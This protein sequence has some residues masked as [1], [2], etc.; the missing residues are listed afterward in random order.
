MPLSTDQPAA[1]DSD[2]LRERIDAALSRYTEF[3]ADC[4][5]Q[6]AAILLLAVVYSSEAFCLLKFVS[7]ECIFSFDSSLSSFINSLN[8]RRTIALFL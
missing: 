7:I 8:F 6:L 1:I 3:D 5:A 2:Q 4:P